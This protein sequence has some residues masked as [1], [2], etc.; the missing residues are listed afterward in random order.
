MIR[1]WGLIA[2]LLAPLAATAQDNLAQFPYWK[3]MSGWWRA[4][5][6]YMDGDLNYNIR[7]YNSLIHVEIDGRNYRETEYKF[8]APSK[9]A[10]LNGR[11]QITENEG[12]ETVSVLTGTLIDTQ[13]T[14]KL[15]G[16]DGT[17]MQVLNADTG[18]RITPN[19]ATG[20]DTYRLLIFAPTADKR[21]RT[22]FGIVSD[23][24]GSGAANALPG[25]KFG[26]LRG[27][28]L[29]REDRIAAEDV[30]RWRGDFRAKNKVKAIVEPGSDGKPAVRRLD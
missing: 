23:T 14:V 22:N 5:N 12:I 29:F 7:S 10:M 25:A 2:A 24:A 11:G 21:Y 1:A 16:H 9:L 18:T 4:E 26:D 30:D 6:T 19:A 17:I 8:Y 3:L 20:V 27:F 13:G 15:A 28:S